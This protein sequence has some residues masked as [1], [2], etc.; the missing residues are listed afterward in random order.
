MVRSGKNA[1]TESAKAVRLLGARCMLTGINL[2]A[3]RDIAEASGLHVTA[4]G[5]V[6][7][8]DDIYALKEIEQFG[9]DSVIV[10]KA[11]YEGALTIDDALAAAHTE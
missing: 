7:S 8:L 10:G 6:A 2:E 9:V 3:T 1:S 4:S 5:G 11:L